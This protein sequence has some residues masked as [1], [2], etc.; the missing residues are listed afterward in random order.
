VK[1]VGSW[2]GT[3]QDPGFGMLIFCLGAELVNLIL[4]EHGEVCREMEEAVLP[5]ISAV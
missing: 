3:K 1:K 2:R 5:S 4:R